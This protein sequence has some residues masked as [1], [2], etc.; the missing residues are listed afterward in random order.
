MFIE[1][2][3]NHNSVMKSDDSGGSCHNYKKSHIAL[4]K[5]PNKKREEMVS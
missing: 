5:W 2:Y 4:N 3:I 1:K